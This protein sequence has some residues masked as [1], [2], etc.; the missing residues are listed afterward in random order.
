M[1]G[2]WRVPSLTGFRLATSCNR[3]IFRSVKLV[4]KQLSIATSQT[5]HHYLDRWY[6]QV[7]LRYI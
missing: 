1:N 5:H 6:V 7:K 4:Y 3:Q 2:I